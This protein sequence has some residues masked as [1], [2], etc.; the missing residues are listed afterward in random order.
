VKSGIPKTKSVRHGE[1]DIG[2][3]A[4]LQAMKMP[5]S[6][7]IFRR[8]G[9][10]RHDLYTALVKLCAKFLEST[11]LADTVG[12]PVGSKEFDEHQMPV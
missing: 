12:S 3:H 8:V 5:L 4:R 7:N 9:T 2:Q 10:D 1:L 6:G 11:Q